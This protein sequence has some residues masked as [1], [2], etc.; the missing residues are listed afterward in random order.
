MFTRFLRKSIEY[1]F[2]YQPFLDQ[3]WFAEES[4]APSAQTSSPE[5]EVSRRNFV[6]ERLAYLCYT[7][8]YLLREV[9]DILKLTNM[10]CAVSALERFL[11]LNLLL[12]PEKS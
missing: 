9:L 7:K 2:H 6:K 8:R 10:P 11:I 1:C 4:L 5:S 12:H 3:F